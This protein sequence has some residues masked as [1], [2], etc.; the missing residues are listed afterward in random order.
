MP[1]DA[2][3]VVAGLST[4][5]DKI[6]ALDAAGYAR[7]DIARFLNKR[8]Q[9]VRNVLE[10]DKTRGAEAAGG[11]V[12]V[13]ESPR[14]WAAGDLGEGLHRLSVDDAGAVRLPPELMKALGLRPGGPAI[15]LFEGDR[16]VILGAEA[17]AQSARDMVMALNL[18]PARSLSDELIADRRRE[19]EADDRG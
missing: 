3:R 19:A 16:L 15:T 6:R 1:Q 9:H 8:Y 10:G 2:E 14:E 13:E 17:A 12:G 11:S 18:D 7:A 4:V 5:S